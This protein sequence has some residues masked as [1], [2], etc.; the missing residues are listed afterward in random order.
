M[1]RVVGGGGKD[2]E[3]SVNFNSP[4]KSK[5]WQIKSYSFVL[6]PKNQKL[7]PTRNKYERTP[8]NFIVQDK[9]QI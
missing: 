1:I 4:Q 3:I 8:Q 7:K 2:N 9:A 5:N 6:V